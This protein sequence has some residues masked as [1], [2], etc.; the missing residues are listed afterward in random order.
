M[1]LSDDKAMDISWD[2]I[3]NLE[4]VAVNRAWIGYSASS[5]T[6]ARACAI[7]VWHL[8]VGTTEQWHG[9]P[10]KM[11]REW[12]PDPSIDGAGG[13]GPA[14]GTFMWAVPCHGSEDTLAAWTLDRPAYRVKHAGGSSCLTRT[15]DDSI[16][17][18]PCNT[19]SA[20]QDF[21][22][23][24]QTGALI[25]GRFAHPPP[26]PPPPPPGQHHSTCLRVENSTTLS[27]GKVVNTHSNKERCGVTLAQCCAMCD[28]DPK[29]N[30]FTLDPD[31]NWGGVCVG[32]SFCW[33]FSSYSAA[34]HGGSMFGSK[35]ALP[36][37][38]PKPPPGSACVKQQ[39]VYGT[40]SH[41]LSLSKIETLADLQNCDRF[42]LTKNGASSERQPGCV[43][44][45][46]SI[47]C[48]AAA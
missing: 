21:M 15:S 14:P 24:L 20:A 46:C 3:T 19:S 37:P 43:R 45:Q 29:C 27:G 4:V 13:D 30:A 10:G 44:S 42:N 40:V 35:G 28:S 26:P 7:D 41:H 38:P 47:H 12:Y 32:K 22:L 25:H 18:L 34:R 2:I 16:A 6:R 33:T 5:L 17:L 36:P 11:V 39:D 23:D 1:N 9:H 8:F 48:A 31:A